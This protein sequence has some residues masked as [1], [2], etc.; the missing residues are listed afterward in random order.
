M[1]GCALTDISVG[2]LRLKFV[3]DSDSV[4]TF[5]SAESVSIR[6]VACTQSL[7]IL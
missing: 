4:T 1:D 5:C 6:R 3:T 2:I 7:K